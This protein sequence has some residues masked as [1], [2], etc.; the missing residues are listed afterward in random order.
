MRIATYNIQHGMSHRQRVIDGNAPIDL[1]LMIS[2]IKE[3]SPDI[4]GLNEVYGKGCFPEFNDQPK[5]IGDALG[6]EHRF[7]FAIDFGD[8]P[9]GTKKPYGNGIVSK[10]PIKECEIIPIPK[11][12]DDAPEYKEPRCIL[13]TVINCDGRDLCVMVVHIGLSRQE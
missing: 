8:E 5:V 9:D 1:P 3:L 6:Y 7:G 11:G 2:V 10:Y 4:C 12:D 13:K